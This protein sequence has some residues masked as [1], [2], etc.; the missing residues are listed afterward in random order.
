MIGERLREARGARSLSLADVAGKAHISAAT[1]SRIENGK[2]GVDLGL[3]LTIVKILRVE[4]ADVLGS[5]EEN[6]S[7]DR[8]VDQ[9]TALQGEQRTRLWRDLAA[10]RRASHERRSDSRAI[11]QKVEELVAQMEYILGEIEAM[12]GKQRRRA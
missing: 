7:G 5:E 2:Q 10:S 12:R 11:N 8:L 3:F 4:P 6:S 9:I 1:L